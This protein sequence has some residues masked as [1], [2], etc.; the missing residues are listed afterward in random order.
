MFPLSTLIN[1]VPE[2]SASV[3]KSSLGMRIN[4]GNFGRE[5]KAEIEVRTPVRIWGSGGEFAEF[6]RTIQ[7]IWSFRASGTK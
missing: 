7:N 2:S 4:G 6:G 3:G 1:T 5:I